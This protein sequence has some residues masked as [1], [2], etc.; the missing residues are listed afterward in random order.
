MTS[1]TCNQ[2]AANVTVENKTGRSKE[3]AGVIHAGKAVL[4]KI[5]G[6]YL[7]NKGGYVKG[8]GYQI[9]P[10]Y[11]SGNAKQLDRTMKQS[12]GKHRGN[13]ETLSLALQGL[14]RHRPK[15]AAKHSMKAGKHRKLAGRHA[16]PR[17]A[18]F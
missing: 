15:S 10:L 13:R 14:M 8:E 16:M 7:K 1:V 2:C 9:L 5:K 17:R 18:F 6:A 4:S 11:I 12:I 3:L